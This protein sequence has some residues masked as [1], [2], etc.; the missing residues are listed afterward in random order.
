MDV[1]SPSVARFVKLG[2]LSQYRF[3]NLNLHNPNNQGKLSKID[4]WEREKN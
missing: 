3:E 1:S 2:N 4:I